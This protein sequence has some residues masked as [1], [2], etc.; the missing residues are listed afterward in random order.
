MKKLQTLE[1]FKSTGLSQKLM[2]SLVGGAANPR[3][4][5]GE[6]CTEATNTGCMSF[7]WDELT[8]DG[9]TIKHGTAEVDKDCED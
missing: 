2:S 7:S 5:G 1:D 8:P 3:T 6:F 4:D 9:W